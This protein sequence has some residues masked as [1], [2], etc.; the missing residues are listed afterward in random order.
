MDAV[1]VAW[2]NQTKP[3][4]PLPFPCRGGYV[5]SRVMGAGYN[6]LRYGWRS[7]SPIFP[8]PLGC[9]LSLE[10][11]KGKLTTET[12]TTAP[13]PCREHASADTGVGRERAPAPES[14][15]PVRLGDIW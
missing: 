4:S 9:V 7:P 3:P 13:G 8:R 14:Q 2:P 5:C 11:T 1:I 10:A 15:G 12:S 6:L